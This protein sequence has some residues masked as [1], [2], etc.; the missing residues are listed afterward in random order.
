MSVSRK[1]R[2][3]EV[4]YEDGGIEVFDLHHPRIAN[5][6]HWIHDRY[7]DNKPSVVVHEIRWVDSG[8]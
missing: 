7:E 3:L 6:N 4:T 8:K 2:T 5:A 1:I